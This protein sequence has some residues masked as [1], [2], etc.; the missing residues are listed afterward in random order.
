MRPK[1]LFSVLSALCAVAPLLLMSCAKSDTIVAPP[2]K[3]VSNPINSDTVSGNIRGTMLTSKGT[4]Y[5]KDSITVL[6]G[7]TL[8]IQPGVRL[9]MLQGSG[10]I[11]IQ[12]NLIAV[13][14]K[15]SPIRITVVDSKRTGAGQ[16]GGVIC[17][18]SN[19]VHL[20]WANF[21]FS[22]GSDASGHAIRTLQVTSNAANT[23]KLIV[24]DCSF[25]ATVDD[26]LEMSG[27]I[28]SILRSTFRYIGG[29]DGDALNMKNGVIGEL[30]Y[31]VVWG[32][33]GNCCKISSGKTSR[34]SD[35]CVHNNTFVAS[36][37][38][39]ITELGYGT[40]VDASAKAEIFN[41]I[42]VDNYEMIEITSQSDSLHVFY[43]NNLFFGSVDSL[44]Q[45][46]RFY[47]SDG[48]G[49]MKSTDVLNRT[50]SPMKGTDPMFVSYAPGLTAA[51]DG[52][53]D[54]HLK[55]GS[56]AFGKGATTLPVNAAG[57]FV[58]D[59]DLGAFTNS[60]ASHQ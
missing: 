27:G 33:G 42:Y 16:W 54:Y 8:T 34:Q 51:S 17:D 40:L 11:F 41:N 57:T 31:N 38:R 60:S 59:A 7:D 25:N 24:E 15:A 6:A 19:L 49:A 13:G 58:G 4:Y 29:P 53:N 18:S 21:E 23:S 3:Q 44:N 43:G 39:R 35:L 22:G 10:T 36:G 9:N 47:P 2:T 32:D 14:T 28:I 48:I 37:F 56:P 26:G 45:A 12:G 46:A 30:A 50:A 52:S 55:S 20:Q 1:I 5:V